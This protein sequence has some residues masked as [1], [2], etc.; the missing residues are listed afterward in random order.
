MCY[1][2]GN[3]LIEKL[4]DSNELGNN[5]WFIGQQLNQRINDPENLEDKNLDEINDEN[6]YK[7]F[8]EFE[9]QQQQAQ[10]SKLINKQAKSLELNDDYIKQGEEEE[11]TDNEE[12]NAINQCQIDSNYSCNQI[13]QIN[14]HLTNGL[15]E[16]YTIPEETEDEELTSPDSVIIRTNLDMNFNLNNVQTQV[17]QNNQIISQAQTVEN[18]IKINDSDVEKSDAISSVNRKLPQ[19]NKKLNSNLST[20]TKNDQWKSHLSS[21]TINSTMNENLIGPAEQPQFS[22]RGKNYLKLK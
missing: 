10:F 4:N 21:T 9:Q 18:L 2:H 1:D 12:L 14:Q 15:G 17:L 6:S 7:K 20:T 3:N 13:N 8:L 19:T 11:N 22:S 16:V 5:Q